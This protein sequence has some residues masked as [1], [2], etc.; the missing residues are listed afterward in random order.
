MRVNWSDQHVYSAK[1]IGCHPSPVYTVSLG[2]TSALFPGSL[3]EPGNEAILTTYCIVVMA[4]T[5]I[6]VIGASLSKPHTSGTVMQNVHVYIHTSVHGRTP[7][8]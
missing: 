2:L 3:V 5:W 8:I 7:N 6:I 4:L 1:F